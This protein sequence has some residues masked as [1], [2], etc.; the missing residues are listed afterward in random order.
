MIGHI[1]LHPFRGRAR[2]PLG[3]G[4][5]VRYKKSIRREA[6][7]ESGGVRYLIWINVGFD[8]PN[9]YYF[10][11]CVCQHSRAR[12]TVFLHTDVRFEVGSP[13]VIAA[14]GGDRGDR[15]EGMGSGWREILRKGAPT[16]NF[17]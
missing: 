8:T 7:G 2:C 1:S 16:L 14:R 4:H 6:F 13:G 5:L 17:G 3:G 10:V 9:L 11:R 15:E 12:L